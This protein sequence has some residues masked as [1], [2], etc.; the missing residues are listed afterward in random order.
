[1]FMCFLSIYRYCI[2]YIVFFKRL[3]FLWAGLNLWRVMTHHQKKFGSILTMLISKYWL[4]NEISLKKFLNVVLVFA[5]LITVRKQSYICC[6]YPLL[7]NACQN[8][9][10]MDCLCH[11][12]HNM[13]ITLLISNYDIAIPL[14]YMLCIILLY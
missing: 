8:F 14:Y 5:C 12:S 6:N 10:L 4:M 1:M 11:L 2:V 13:C 9:Q 7:A 3:I